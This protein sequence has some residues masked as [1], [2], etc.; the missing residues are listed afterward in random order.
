MLDDLQADGALLIGD[1][2]IKASFNPPTRYVTDLGE[3][4]L[5]ATGHSMTYAVWAIKKS[6]AEQNRQRICEIEKQLEASLRVG[7]QQ[8]NVLIQRA[9][10]EIGG[11]PLF[12]HNYYE[13]L[14]FTFGSEEQQGLLAYDEALLK[15]STPAR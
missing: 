14:R 9:V 8:K 10:S 5:E 3:W 2:A 12:W 15:W 1:D 13:Q 4:W 7:L 11:S 6:Y